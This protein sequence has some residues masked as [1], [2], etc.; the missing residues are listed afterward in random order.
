MISDSPSVSASSA[1]PPGIVRMKSLVRANTLYQNIIGKVHRQRSSDSNSFLSSNQS[2]RFQERSGQIASLEN[3]MSFGLGSGPYGEPIRHIVCANQSTRIRAQRRCAEQG[4]ISCPRCRLVKYCSERC[5]KQ[6]WPRHSST[7]AHPYLEESWQ[8]GWVMQD[9]PPSFASSSATYSPSASIFPAFDNMNL[10]QNEFGELAVTDKDFKICFAACADIRDLIE[11]VNNLP[12]N[13][14]GTFDV[15]LNNPDPIITNRNL[16][17]LY[18]LLNPEP[19]IDEAAELAIHLMY[20]AVLSAP[21]A[22]FL[23]RSLDDI[24]RSTQ[25]DGENGIDFSSFRVGLNTRG[26]GK[27]YSFQT[28]AGVKPPLE[29]FTS[30]TYSLNTALQDRA[31]IL[32]ALENVDSWDRFLSRLRP[33]HRMAFQRFRETGVLA[34]F[35]VDTNRFTHPNRLMFSS[36]GQWLFRA[37]ILNPFQ[38][39]DSTSVQLSRAKYSMVDSA[40]IFG[41]LFFHLKSQFHRF[42]SQ[43]KD[44]HINFVLTQFDSRILAKGIMD[45]VIPIFEG[46]CFDRIDTRDMMDEIG[47]GECLREWGPL[48]NCENPHASLLMHSRAWHDQRPYALARC[49]SHAVLTLFMR[50]CFEIPSLSIKLKDVFVQGLRS[51]A[52]LR[53]IESLDAFYDHDHFFH[54]FLSTENTDSIAAALDLQLRPQHRIHPRRFGTPLDAHAHSLPDLS[55]S[56]FYDLVSLCEVDFSTRFLEFGWRH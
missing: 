5:Q 45:G 33:S 42:A 56:R 11:T 41:C 47:I 23:Q 4:L 20:S 6:H 50:K 13:Y 10:D 15:L 7:C 51:P 44:L 55:R 16:I 29:V 17:I 36:Q 53:L 21:C 3:L 2:F 30:T 12:S 25:S 39:W 48:L 24:Y 38:G 8:P 54:D 37:D 40:D 1:I 22:A 26:R 43:V 28:I 18:A 46:G 49:N 52:L 35:S 34:P 27:I 19:S 31:R 9:R 14:S 32:G